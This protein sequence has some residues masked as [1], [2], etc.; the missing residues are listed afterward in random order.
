VKDYLGRHAV[1]RLDV[2]GEIIDRAHASIVAERR[3]LRSV[4]FLGALVTERISGESTGG[5]LAVLE[6]EAHLGYSAPMQRHSHGDETFVVLEGYLELVVDGERHVVGPGSSMSAPRQSVHGFVVASPIARFL[7][8]HYPA[9][10]DRLPFD[11][12]TP[13]LIA[14]GERESH[15]PSTVVPPS[16]TR[17]I[18]IAAI[19]GIEFLGPPPTLTVPK[20]PR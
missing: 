7:T 17:Q 16:R 15:Q 2:R 9:G 19:H 20:E 1:V 5:A 10:A 8:L 12:G 11:T 6:H 13:A 14:P 18:R 4:W 3:G